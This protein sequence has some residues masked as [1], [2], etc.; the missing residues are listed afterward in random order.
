VPFSMHLHSNEMKWSSGHCQTFP[1]SQAGWRDNMQVQA[2]PS[3]S[4][5]FPEADNLQAARL[6][7]FT[8]G[9]NMSQGNTRP[10]AHREHSDIC[11]CWSDGGK[12][13]E[14]KCL[15]CPVDCYYKH[16]KAS[17]RKTR[18]PHTYQPHLHTEDNLLK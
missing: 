6:S 11:Y 3:G 7:S 17:C 13:R 14:D 4:S 18:P 5:G 12:N 8:S 10:V 16:R 2:R 1:S 9:A 15:K